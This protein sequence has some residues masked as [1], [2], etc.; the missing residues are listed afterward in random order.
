MTSEK[1]ATE[2]LMS[3]FGPKIIG[4]AKSIAE[5]GLN[6]T[7]SWAV[8]EEGGRYIV[9][10]GNRRLVACR[11][12]DNPSK[13]PKEHIRTFERIKSSVSAAP[14]DL[15][16]NCVTFERRA[17]ARYWIQIKH[18]GAGNGEGTAPWGPEMVYL[19][20]VAGGGR[21]VEWNEFWYWLEEAYHNDAILIDRIHQARREQYTLMDRVYNWKVK[22]LLNT[23]FD[24]DGKLHA[25]VDSGKIR[26]F[27][28]QLVT[29]MLAGKTYVSDSLADRPAFIALSSRT[30]NDRPA[31]GKVLTDL[32]EKTIGDADVSPASKAPT[33]H[34]ATNA[35]P[36]SE[37]DNPTLSYAN[38]LDPSTKQE[39]TRE[40]RNRS[41]RPRKSDTHLY[42]GVKHSNMPKRVKDI[43]KECNRIEIKTS[44]ETASIMARV[45]VEVAVD[46]FIKDKNLRK[47]EKSKLADKIAIVMRHLDPDL[48]S[49]TP[50]RDDLKGTWA[51]VRTDKADGHFVRD[52]NECV[53]EHTFIAAPEMAEK[54]HRLFAPLLNAIND[55]LGKRGSPAHG[56]STG[57]EKGQS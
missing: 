39:R 10:E 32:W 30:L 56:V 49:K 13:A 45:A 9:L 15:K 46:A 43:L 53:H 17:D 16:P 41:D 29:G 44:P 28:E 5:H 31:T 47:P 3:E 20:Q 35:D 48:D 55:D 2:R 57:R 24:H 12:L 14:E 27:I 36:A 42:Y 4:L 51:A 34:A 21:P 54:A 22:D 52:L 50:S 25:S 18:H 38:P 26:P 37:L 7:E 19:H 6:P 23:E 11:M 8:V 33:I 40:V 1:E